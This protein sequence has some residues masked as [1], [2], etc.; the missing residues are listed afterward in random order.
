MARNVQ[1]QNLRKRRTL[2]IAR[3]HFPCRL[4]LCGAN[5]FAEA[6]TR[7][8]TGT[9]TSR[10][11]RQ[12]T[13]RAIGWA[14]RA[15]T[16]PPARGTVQHYLE[17]RRP[18]RAPAETLPSVQWSRQA[19][20]LSLLPVLDEP[21]AATGIGRATALAFASSKNSTDFRASSLNS[22][23]RQRASPSSP[24]R[25]PNSSSPSLVGLD[26]DSCGLDHDGKQAL[27]DYFDQWR[28]SIRAR[29]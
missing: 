20:S 27:I 12:V 18:N 11:V 6:W 5:L 29:R 8:W 9:A 14:S 25:L 2:L 17:L 26:R 4:K 16:V 15:R 13:R 22:T 10:R 21:G 19:H 7:R 1:R 24:M 3:H 28:G 23:T